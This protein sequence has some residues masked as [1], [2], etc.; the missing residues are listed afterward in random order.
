MTLADI[1]N[2]IYFLTKTNSSSYTNANMLIAINAANNRVASLILKADDRWQW[3][4]T[5]QSD[6]P[7][8]T[9]S[10]V[11]GQKDY[12]VATTHLTID[13][14][15]V[16]DA[17]GNWIALEQI[18]Q[19]SLKR[20]KLTALTEHQETSGTPNQYDVIGS[21]IFLYPTPNYSQS[22]SLKVYF[23]RG[24]SEFTSGQLT[25][26]TASPGFNSLFHELIPL[27]VAYDYAVA[28]GLNTTSAFLASI[29][30]REK[31]LWDFYGLRN[32]DMRPRFSI[33]SDS[34]K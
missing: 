20:G 25:A 5:N 1:Q 34:N 3:D 17:S 16:K 6:L 9:T 21:S 15:E 22:A 8:A 23:T 27:W 12:S 33:S 13:R 26:G 14:V 18:D 24:P 28:N 4:D 2:K 30:L 32:R 31:D 11:S 19:Q 10:L 7:I 29:Q